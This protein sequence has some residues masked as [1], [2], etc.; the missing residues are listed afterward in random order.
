MGVNRQQFHGLSSI[1]PGAGV[2]TRAALRQSPAR[3]KV[4]ESS[5]RLHEGRGLFGKVAGLLDFIRRWLVNLPFVFFYLSPA[6]QNVRHEMRTEY[7]PTP[8]I[9]SLLFA[10][11]QTP[12]PTI[13]TRL[14]A[15]FASR[16][17]NICS[18]ARQHDSTFYTRAKAI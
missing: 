14:S 9:A 7:S 6:R 1:L 17:F 13:N 11:F 4:A 10:N 12:F 16:A 15:Y 2:R 5:L 3:G 18:C 8:S